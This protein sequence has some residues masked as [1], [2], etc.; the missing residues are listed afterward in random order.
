M[1]ESKAQDFGKRFFELRGP[2]AL[3]TVRLKTG[4]SL[5]WF[6]QWRPK[7]AREEAECAKVFELYAPLEG[8]DEP[9]LHDVES[10]YSCM[11]R[12]QQEHDKAYWNSVRQSNGASKPQGL[13]RSPRV[14]QVP[15]FPLSN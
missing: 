12:E 14:F 11:I 8:N 6:P 4:E 2:S 5:R 9:R 13:S 3:E 10:D 1:T 7:Y 15:V